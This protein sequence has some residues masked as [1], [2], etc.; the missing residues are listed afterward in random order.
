MYIILP[1]FS[2]SVRV[3]S[4]GLTM[5]MVQDMRSKFIMELVNILVTISQHVNISLH[6]VT[7]SSG[8]KAFSEQLHFRLIKKSFHFGTDLLFVITLFKL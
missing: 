6:F 2:V 7:K 4:D 1:G 5:E 3:S 8:N